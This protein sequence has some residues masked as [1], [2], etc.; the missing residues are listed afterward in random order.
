MPWGVDQA[1]AMAGIGEKGSA[2][3]HAGEMAAFAFDGQ[4]LL[5]ATLRSHQTHQRFRLMGVELG[6]RE[7]SR[8]RAD[9]SGESG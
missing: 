4:F 6:S 5:D 1:N 7:R 9:Q 2:R 3:V 8:Q